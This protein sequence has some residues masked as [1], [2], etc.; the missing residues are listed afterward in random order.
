MGDEL[1]PKEIMNLASKMAQAYTAAVR[2]YMDVGG[3]APDEAEAKVRE[4]SDLAWL[5][6]YVR[7]IPPDQVTWSQL[8]R[9][10]G[11]DAEVCKAAW[12]RLKALAQEELESGL[13][14]ADTVEEY[15]WG[16]WGEARY[17]AI[18]QAMVE[19]WQPRGGGECALVDM[20][21]Q[22]Y[23]TYLFWLKRLM[24]RASID[25]AYEEDDVRRDGKWRPTR[26]SASEATEQAAAMV[27][28]FNRIF[29]RTLRALR[30]LRR[31]APNVTI[32]NAGQ[33]NIAQQQTNTAT[34]GEGDKPASGDSVGQ[35]MERH[36]NP[37]NPLV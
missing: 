25:A 12:E 14:G 36:Y 18:R 11:Q 26:I 2:Y 13:R 6:E 31:Y 1:Q 24:Q 35:L 17:I 33:V 9:L 10:E 30:D 29:L 28:R 5:E 3:L 20:L 37:L 7:T 23:S 34:L 22:T 16:P 8:A 15:G 27:D 32:Q 21:A 4:E 19:G